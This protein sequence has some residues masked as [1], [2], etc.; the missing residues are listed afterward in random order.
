MRLRFNNGNYWEK[1]TKGELTKIVI[2]ERVPKV[3]PP[4]E[5][6][7]TLSQMVSYRDSEDTEIARAHQYLRPNGEIGASGKP[8]PKRLYEG[9]ILYRLQKDPKV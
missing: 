5:P 3:L 1:S 7:N 4:G 6:A 8:D 9:G 2:E